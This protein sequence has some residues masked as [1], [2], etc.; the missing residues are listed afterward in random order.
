[1]L[2]GVLFNAHLLSLGRNDFLLSR[3]RWRGFKGGKKARV[4]G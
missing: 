1:M 4:T 3:V 2:I